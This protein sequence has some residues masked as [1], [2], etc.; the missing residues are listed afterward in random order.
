MIVT[1]QDVDIV[2]GIVTTFGQ[3]GLNDAK[4]IASKSGETAATDSS[5][6]YSIRCNKRDMLKVS[7]AYCSPDNH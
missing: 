4:I 2:S 6:F 1:A 3:Y 7:A 5:G